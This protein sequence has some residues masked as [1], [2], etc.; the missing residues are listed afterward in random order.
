MFLSPQVSEYTRFVLVAK[1]LIV[2]KYVYIYI[3]I[4]LS[5]S[6]SLSL[7]VCLCVCVFV[8]CECESSMIS[9][10]FTV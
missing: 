10:M 4:Y 6:L 8:G 3:Y 7:S 2:E 1:F 9:G 5:L